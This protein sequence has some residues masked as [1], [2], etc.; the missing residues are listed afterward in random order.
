[1]PLVSE[2]EPLP[3]LPLAPAPAKV[4]AGGGTGRKAGLKT[5]C[6]AVIEDYAAALK[7]F[8]HHADVR[9]AVGKLVRA[10]VRLNKAQS[11]IPGVKVV[12]ERRAA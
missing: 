6:V 10:D 3:E 2:P 4:Q 12:E 5:G 1:M 11:K 9:A 8:E 7:H